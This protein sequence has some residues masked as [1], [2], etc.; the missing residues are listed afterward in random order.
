MQ[1]LQ[2]IMLLAVA[3]LAFNAFSE[4]REISFVQLQTYSEE[5]E[6]TLFYRYYNNKNKNIKNSI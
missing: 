2:I 3:A 1:D 5:L 4:K 6:F